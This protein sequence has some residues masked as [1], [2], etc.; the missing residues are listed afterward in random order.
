[1][2]CITYKKVTLILFFLLITGQTY[3]QDP[4][5]IIDSLRARLKQDPPKKEKA[6]IYSNLS[7]YYNSIQVDSTLY[8]GNLGLQ[9]AKELKDNGLIAQSYSDLGVGYFVKG[10]I[11]KSLEFYKKALEI[12]IREKNEERIASLHIKIGSNYYKKMALEQ[13]MSYF[14]KALKYYEANNQESVTA[15]LEYNIAI[16]YTFL[17]NYPKALQFLKR[18]E[19][20]FEKKGIGFELANVHNGIGNVYY[21]TKDYSQA[22]RHFEKAATEA[23]K[24]Q[25]FTTQAT[26]YNNLSSIYSDLGKYGQAI[27]Y[28]QK[29]LEIRE[30]K[31]MEADA[32]SSYITLATIYNKTGQ[33]GKAAPFLNKSLS[34]FKTNGGKEKLSQIYYELVRSYNG[35]SKKDS[36][37]H[38]LDLYTNNQSEVLNA[39]VI[40][41]SGELETKYQT[42][43]KEKQIQKQ[44]AEIAERNLKLEQKNRI[45]YYAF[46]LVGISLFIGY[47]FYGRQK[48][49]QREAQLKEARQEIETQNKLNE[50]RLYISRDLHDNIGAQLAFIISSLDNLK[51]SFNMQEQ[52]LG[53]VSGIC[54]FTRDTIT[55]LRDTIWAMNKERLTIADLEGRIRNFINSAREANDTIDFSFEVNPLLLNTVSISS[56]KGVSIYRI[57]QEGVHNAL[58]HSGATY[59]QVRITGD[60]PLSITIE[61][62]GK[63]FDI[64]GEATGYGIANIKK[65]V[66]DCNGDLNLSS[67]EKGTVL[68]ATLDIND[69]L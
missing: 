16:V 65:R 7:W 40:K 58:K 1:M 45:I 32:I 13:A 38:Y 68:T 66:A 52:L 22:I 4:G 60:N 24:S 8:F 6:D 17:K 25:N 35:L 33:Y 51:Y 37:A 69:T 41:V 57:I 18:S 20:Y 34:Y 61:D 36:V 29:S 62:N 19:T 3:S 15:S 10:D 53:K 21:L 11:D 2:C 55:E 42:E 59:I 31:K 64:S 26:A 47:L 54:T 39:E 14:L 9:L 5:K 12:R 27:D 48:R 43:K 63:G 30:S 44:R 50:Q 67:S 56:V 46:A 49:I 23:E 28:S